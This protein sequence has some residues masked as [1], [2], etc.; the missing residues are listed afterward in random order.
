MTNRS[1]EP[2]TVV[3]TV[4][5]AEPIDRPPLNRAAR[6]RI[7]KEM[8]GRDLQQRKVIARSLGRED[9]RP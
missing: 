1:D 5:T 7:A 6:R 4:P 3:E 2:Q 9:V 8:A